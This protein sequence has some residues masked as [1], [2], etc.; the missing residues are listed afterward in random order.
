MTPYE[1]RF[2]IFKQAMS[3]AETDYQARYTTVAMWNENPKNTVMM[4]FPEYPSY[5]EIEALAGRINEF[6]S[7]K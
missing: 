5:E 2:E 6:V 4:E 1:L 7:S 3:L